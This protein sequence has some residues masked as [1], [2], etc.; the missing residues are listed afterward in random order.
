MD[1][2]ALAGEVMDFAV[3]LICDS[4]SRAVSGGG[5]R[6]PPCTTADDFDTAMVNCYKRYSFLAIQIEKLLFLSYN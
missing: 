6:R 3:I 5:N 2:A 1:Y 4:F